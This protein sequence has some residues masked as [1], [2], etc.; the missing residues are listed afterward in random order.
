LYNGVGFLWTNIAIYV[1]SYLY[2][3]DNSVR[4]DAIFAIDISLVFCQAFGNLFG[5]YLLNSRGVHP[6]IVIG[7]GGF[8]SLGGMFASSYVQRLDLFLILYGILGSFGS[9]MNYFV[10]ISCSWEYF[11]DHKGKVAGILLAAF[12]FSSF[13]LT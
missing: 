5:T 4:A 11:P 1:L 12:G 6:K 8:I 13:F 2:I 9:G 3:Y 7:L 10:P